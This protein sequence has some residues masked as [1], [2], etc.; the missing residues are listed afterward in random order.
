MQ[1]PR[2]MK[3]SLVVLAVIAVAG[4]VVWKGGLHAPPSFEGPSAGVQGGPLDLNALRGRVVVLNFWATWCAACLHELPELVKFAQTRAKHT[5]LAVYGVSPEAPD[6]LQRY[7]QSHPLPY[8]VV[9]DPALLDQ[10]DV[11]VIP[12]TVV[13]DASGKVAGRHVGVIAQRGLER[14]ALPLMENVPSC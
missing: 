11:E 8:A 13:L 9:S 1:L 10:F 3:L 12:T 6:P 7:T 4:T 5:C 14:M 2:T